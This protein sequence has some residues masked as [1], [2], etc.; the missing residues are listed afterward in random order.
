MLQSNI[1]PEEDIDVSIEDEAVW[2]AKDRE[3][4]PQQGGDHCFLGF[5]QRAVGSIGQ[6]DVGLEM[7]LNHDINTVALFSRS[8]WSCYKSYA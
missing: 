1:F 5:K 3:I 8:S 6:S 4:H 7:T 2:E